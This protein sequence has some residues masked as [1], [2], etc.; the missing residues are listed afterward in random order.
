M[1]SNV[2]T[3]DWLSPSDFLSEPIWLFSRLVF[4]LG[5]GFSKTLYASSVI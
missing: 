2:S 3:L 5:F 4:S 1:L